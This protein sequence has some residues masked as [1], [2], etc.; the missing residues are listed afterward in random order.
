MRREQRVGVARE[1]RPPSGERASQLP[2]VDEVDIAAQ[3]RAHPGI[4]GN[5]QPVVRLRMHAQAHLARRLHAV[6]AR[7]VVLGEQL[8]PGRC[9]RGSSARTPACRAARRAGAAR[10]APCPPRRGTCSRRSAAPTLGLPRLRLERRGEA[11]QRAQLRPR[12]AGPASVPASNAAFERVVLRRGAGWPRC[13]T[14]SSRVCRPRTRDVGL[15]DV[16]V[17]RHRRR[18]PPWSSEK[19]SITSSGSMVNLR[20]GM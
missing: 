20:P 8:A 6:D 3:R 18:S 7:H 9:W 15:G 14:R 17:E 19:R 11:P 10:F 5:A 1:R 13:G 16:E 2:L 12:T 4:A